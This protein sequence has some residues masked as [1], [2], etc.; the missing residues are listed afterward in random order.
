MVASNPLPM[1]NECRRH[2]FITEKRRIGLCAT[3]YSHENERNNKYEDI[4]L[5]YVIP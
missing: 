1:L 5:E 4:R 2:A 3:N